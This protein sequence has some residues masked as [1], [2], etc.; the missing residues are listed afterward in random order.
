MEVDPSANEASNGGGLMGMFGGM[1]AG[2]DEGGS[3]F[4]KDIM[5]SVPGID[6]A[7]SFGEVIKSLDEY[8][9]HLYLISIIKIGIH[10]K[11]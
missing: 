11:F 7:T 6:E 4:M 1:G 2:S 5:A 3:S 9:F 8:K 10:V